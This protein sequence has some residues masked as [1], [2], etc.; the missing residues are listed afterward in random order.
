MVIA[1]LGLAPDTKRALRAAGV[2]NIDQLQRPAIELLA[3]P[4]ITG[5]VVYD[6]ARRLQAHGLSLRTKVGTRPTVLAT[7]V[8]DEELV[9]GLVMS[10]AMCV[11]RWICLG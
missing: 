8:C 2:K 3:L 11:V 6:V 1:D 7:A 10:A 5:A 4:G 9:V